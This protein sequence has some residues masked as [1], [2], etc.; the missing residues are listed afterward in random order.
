MSNRFQVPK[1]SAHPDS[2]WR[3]TSKFV[4]LVHFSTM[5]TFANFQNHGPRPI[6]RT[7]QAYW[8]DPV[9]HLRMEGCVDGGARLTTP[10]P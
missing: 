6:Y 7:M 2:V 8:V 4:S 9:R 3:D 5:L 1:P 10:S